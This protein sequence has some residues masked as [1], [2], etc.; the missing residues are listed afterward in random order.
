MPGGG[1][2]RSVVPWTE[3]LLPNVRTAT[4]EYRVRTTLTQASASVRSEPMLVLWL[5]KCR[6]R[7]LPPTALREQYDTTPRQGKCERGSE[8]DEPMR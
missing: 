2:A 4:M 6:P 1:D 8:V 3:G 5:T 7:L